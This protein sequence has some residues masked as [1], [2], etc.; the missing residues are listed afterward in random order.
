MPRVAKTNRLKKPRKKR[1]ARGQKPREEVVDSMIR[2][3]MD[4]KGLIPLLRTSSSVS[5]ASLLSPMLAPMLQDGLVTTR[6]NSIKRDVVALDCEMVGVGVKGSRSVLGRCSIVGYDGNVVYDSY[7]RPCE[8]ITDFRTGIRCCHMEHAK[9]FEE[10]SRE[11]KEILANKMIVGHDL[12][13]NFNAINLMDHPQSHIRDTSHLDILQLGRTPSLKL[14]AKV[15]LNYDIQEGSHCSVIDARICMSIYKLVEDSW[16][17]SL[18]HVEYNNCFGS[19]I[20]LP[21]TGLSPIRTDGICNWS[22]PSSGFSQSKPSKRD[23]SPCSSSSNSSSSPFDLSKVQKHLDNISLS[24]EFLQN[25]VGIHCDVVT[26]SSGEKQVARCAILGGTKRVWF[27][28]H[29]HPDGEVKDYDLEYT[30][31]KTQKLSLPFSKK[32]AGFLPEIKKILTGKTIVGYKLNEQ[33]TALGLPLSE[34]TY[35]DTAESLLVRRNA[36]LP[37]DRIPS[38][39][40]L[41][42]ILHRQH[43]KKKVLKKA[44]TSLVI[45]KMFAKEWERGLQRD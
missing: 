30:G 2:V 37:L 42:R 24:K 33:F 21:P 22:Q 15:C 36:N 31:L 6:G 35:R 38:L 13:N 9:P 3:A 43:Y 11:I 25:I 28:K 7:V 20:G 40:D 34:Y 39:S 5:K 10:A 17:K 27:N 45:Y 8:P 44:R 23:D 14:L 19:L 1:L 32:L 4:N 12:K 41:T 26:M 16:E 29:I 18:T